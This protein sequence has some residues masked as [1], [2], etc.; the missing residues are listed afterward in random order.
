MNPMIRKELLER[1]R[2][3]RGWLLP[4]LYLVAVCGVAAFFYFETVADSPSAAT[5]PADVGV[6]LFLATLFAQL[7]V[8]LLLTPIFSAGAITTE[9]EQLTLSSLLVTLL[10]PF[11]IWTGKFLAALMFIALLLVVGLPLVSMALAFG[12]I[13]AADLF[14][15]TATTF[16]VLSTVCAIGVLC[17]TIFRRSVHSTAVAYITVVAL[18]VVTAVAYSIAVWWWHSTHASQHAPPW[19]VDGLLWLNPFTAVA[20]AAQSSYRNDWL[21]SLVS[22]VVVGAAAAFVAIGRL[23][24]IEA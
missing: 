8:L 3:R 13:T 15:T 4:S 21:C 7:T 20:Y 12:G 9:R 1:M 14:R 23:R 17:S 2:E 6:G 10:S 11:E 16:V 19:Y 18:T 24:R 22:F 5:Q